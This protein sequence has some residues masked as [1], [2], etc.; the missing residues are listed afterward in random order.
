MT[1]YY[2]SCGIDQI[3]IVKKIQGTRF[4]QSFINLV[5]FAAPELEKGPSLSEIGFTPHD[6]SH[7]CRNIYMILTRM[8]P[9]KFYDEYKE[10]NV[11]VLLVAVLFHDWG[12]TVEWSPEIREKHSEISKQYI[13]QS[14]INNDVQSVIK[15]NIKSNYVEYISDIIYAHSDL[16]RNGVIDKR[17]FVEVCQKYEEAGVETKGENETINV[18][19]LA[20]L[21]RLADELDISYD[22]IENIDYVKRAN[23]PASYEH[24]KLCEMFKM[25]QKSNSDDRTLIIQM[26]KGKYDV[27]EDFE[28]ATRAAQILE[29]YNKILKE[30]DEMKTRV[31]CNTMHVKSSEVWKINKISLKV[32]NGI[33]LESDA[34]KKVLN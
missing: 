19:F 12:M 33:D 18:P 7:H 23:V 6:F 30:F 15:L 8:L 10:E 25:V 3:E 11:F 29:R 16:K 32:P 14:F 17:T 5:N 31:L 21:L 22:R 26:E 27:G 4:E 24:F 1:D 13:L 9:E 20:A 34:K 28:K 2:R